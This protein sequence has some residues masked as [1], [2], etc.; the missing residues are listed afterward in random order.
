[1]IRQFAGSIRGGISGGFAIS[2]VPLMAAAA[3]AVDFSNINRLS[4]ELQSA[5]DAASIEIAVNLNSGLDDEGLRSLGER[6]LLANLPDRQN[7]IEE[8]F[9]KFS[10]LGVTVDQ[11]GTQHLSTEAHHNYSHVMPGDVFSQVLPAKVA[12]LSRV[13]ARVGDLACVYALNHT[14][15]R[16]MEAGGSANISMDGCVVASNSSADDAIYV[17]GSAALHADCVQSSGGIDATSGLTTDCATTRENAWRLPDPFADL[18]DPVPPML[19]TNP[20]KSDTVVWPGRYSNLSLN[21]DK[22]LEPGLYYI[23]GSLKIQGSITGTGVTFFLKN[24]GISVNGDAE[25]SLS[26]P[27]SGIHAGMLFYSSRTNTSSHSFNGNGTTDLNG[28]LYFP[29]GDLTFNGNNTATSNCLRIVADTIKMSGSSDM[30]SDCSAE[31][32]GREARVS[33]PYY[34][35]R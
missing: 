3:M 23:E 33:G 30:K 29:V 21:G 12:T 17:G 20:K 4:S 24:G 1:M 15:P 31:L 2:L 25:L 32:G 22:T 11:H 27:T 8:F 26:A 10:Y 7:D 28:Y 13:S 5:L 16:A 6:V 9:P 35:S 34:I 14:A 18:A 19:L